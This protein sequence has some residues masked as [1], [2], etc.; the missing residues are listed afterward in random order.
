M[1]EVDTATLVSRIHA[2]PM[3]LVLAITGGGSRAIAELLEVP[4]GSRTLLEAVVPYSPKALEAWLGA[5]PEQFCS[6]RTARAM[7]MT[8]FLK[9]FQL[10]GWRAENRSVDAGAAS[11]PSYPSPILGGKATNVAPVV[12]IG[13]TAS[14][15]TDWLKRGTHR[16]HV[17][18]QGSSTTACYSIELE[19]DRRSRPDEEAVAMRLVLNA[20][21][22]ASS[23]TDRLE[24]KTLPDE[25]L[26]EERIDAP[27]AWQSL[28]A[29]TVS[30]VRH[31]NRAVQIYDPKRTGA[32][33]VFPGAFNPLHDGHQRMMEL[34]ADILG[35][36]VE[37]EI[38]IENVDKPPLDFVEMDGRLRQFEGQA[39]WFTR[40]STFVR[41]AELFPGAIFIVG[42]DTIRRISDPRYYGDN[43]ELAAAAIDR[44]RQHGGRFLVFGRARGGRL[45]SLIQLP[46][47]LRE[48]CTE[49]PL[50]QFRV[51]ISSTELRRSNED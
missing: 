45:E 6:A 17:A 11:T 7:A 30:A 31:E 9:G 3:W 22:D 23:L 28:L 40:A 5:V 36:P 27:A 35:M 37:F 21:A 20:A 50:E 34:A 16:I 49:V 14:L 24:L 47:A 41:K 51:D 18:W 39:V 1:T 29:G 43:H 38:S 4:G 25:P 13:C 12:G 19:K 42:A 32:V 46:Q 2:A 44:I 15:R 10:L 33:A 8:A 48:L 26:V